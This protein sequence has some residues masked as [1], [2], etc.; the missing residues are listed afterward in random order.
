MRASNVLLLVVC[1]C[2]VV[3]SW[4]AEA[5]P[6]LEGRSDLTVNISIALPPIGLA[7]SLTSAGGERG[8]VADPMVENHE[9][10][11]R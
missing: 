8:K 6:R 9:N 3:H 2:L 10:H 4:N 5:R 7:T 11:N 1:F